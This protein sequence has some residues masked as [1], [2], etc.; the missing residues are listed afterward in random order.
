[1]PS[2]APGRRTAKTSRMAQMASATSIAARFAAVAS[3]LAMAMT[4]TQVAAE[5]A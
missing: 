3:L 1:M 5:S 2:A 4:D